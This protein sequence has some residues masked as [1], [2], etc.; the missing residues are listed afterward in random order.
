M[1]VLLVDDEQELVAT[2]A[3]RLDMRGI[4]ATWVTDYRA[5]LEAVDRDEYDLAL[6]DVRLPEMNGLDLKRLIEAKQPGMK[7]IFLTGHG[8]EEDFKACSAESGREYYL[9]KP[10]QIEVLIAKLNEIC[11]E[12]GDSK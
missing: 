4:S 11:Q 7:F 6:L 5:A 8:S 12:Q 9:I 3:E 1:R 10:V 2:L